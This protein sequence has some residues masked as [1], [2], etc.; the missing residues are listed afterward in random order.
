M[1]HPV[2]FATCAFFMLVLILSWVGY[3][4]IY[5]PGR[6]MRQ[7]GRPVITTDSERLVDAGGETEPSTVVS[8]LH[9]IGSR[10]PASEAE[11]MCIRDRRKEGQAAPPATMQQ[12]QIVPVPAP[13]PSPNPGLTPSTG[14]TAK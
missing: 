3:R 9:G 14:G 11:E 12:I 8:F 1:E 7:L 5:K 4:L 6:F 2:L 10:V 13:L